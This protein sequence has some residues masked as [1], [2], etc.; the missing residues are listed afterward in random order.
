MIRCDRSNFRKEGIDH[1]GRKRLGGSGRQL[2]TS[3]LQSGN[4]MGECWCSALFLNQS[5]TPASGMVSPTFQIW[6]EVCPLSDSNHSFSEGK[7][8]SRKLCSCLPALDP[9]ESFGTCYYNLKSVKLLEHVSK[10]DSLK[11]KEL[12]EVTGHMLLSFQRAW[13]LVGPTWPV[14]SGV[15]GL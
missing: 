6:L 1:R 12:L 5:R 8:W 9:C 11:E 7:V 13:V 10:C 14:V 15:K 4:K 2:V 3:Y